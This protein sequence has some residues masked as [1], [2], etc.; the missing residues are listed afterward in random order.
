[1]L[2]FWGTGLLQVLVKIVIAGAFGLNISRKITEERSTLRK[3]FY[4]KFAKVNFCLI[5]S[6]NIK[7]VCY[8]L[9]QAL[10]GKSR[11]ILHLI[12]IMKFYQS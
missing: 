4:V 7:S 3:E 2:L 5:D 6:Q 10:K 9:H 1:M 11:D 12:H 8:F